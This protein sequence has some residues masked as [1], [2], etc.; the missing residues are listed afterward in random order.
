V[1]E[2]EEKTAV[3]PSTPPA[4]T[5][6]A[7]AAKPVTSPPRGVE[8][9]GAAAPPPAE[10]ASAVH[11]PLPEPAPLHPPDLSSAGAKPSPPPSAALSAPRLAPSLRHSETVVIRNP[12]PTETA[13]GEAKRSLGLTVD[14][15]A[16]VVSVL[17]DTPA[18]R[19]NLRPGDR[20]TAVNG[21]AVRNA[22]ELRQAVSDAADAS[23]ITLDVIR[24]V[25]CAATG[26]VL[27]G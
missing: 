18:E 12:F 22:E 3:P 14:A 8:P 27:P 21:R 16:V 1:R 24:S 6:P 11:V 9:V 25:A 4:P 10:P 5:V 15:D 20:L 26:S 17:P 19:H 23:E 2:T 13:E 7:V